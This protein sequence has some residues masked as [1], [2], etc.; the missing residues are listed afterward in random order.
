MAMTNVTYSRVSLTPLCSPGQ[1]SLHF[2]ALHCDG[3]LRCE[4]RD[5][6]A[7]YA[8]HTQ[9]V[10]LLIDISRRDTPRHLPPF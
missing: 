1:V 6:H 9:K 10:H 8:H 2:R 5:S 7:L 4:L 3:T